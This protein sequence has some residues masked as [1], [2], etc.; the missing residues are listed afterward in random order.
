MGEPT[1][2]T[3]E[4]REQHFHRGLA[5]ERALAEL[6]AIKERFLAALARQ[7][8]A[9]RTQH[10]RAMAA[11]TTGEDPD[12]QAHQQDL[13]LD[14]PALST[15]PNASP[16]K[17]EQPDPEPP[18]GPGRPRRRPA[19]EA[20]GEKRAGKAASARTATVAE[21][22]AAPVEDDAVP[23]PAVPCCTCG[24]SL[25][26][27]TSPQGAV[28]A[29]RAKK[30]LAKPRCRAFQLG[31]VL[32]WTL[33]WQGGWRETNDKPVFFLSQRETDIAK[34]GPLLPQEGGLVYVDPVRLGRGTDVLAVARAKG[35]WSCVKGL[36]GVPL[37][38]LE[39]VA[40][41]LAE[42]SPAAPAAP[43]SAREKYLAETR[44]RFPHFTEDEV[45]RHVENFLRIDGHPLAAPPAFSG[46]D[47]TALLDAHLGAREEEREY[48]DELEVTGTDSAC[49]SC[50][51]REGPRARLSFS[52]HSRP[53]GV[54][55]WRA[56]KDSRCLGI[57]FNLWLCSRCC[58]PEALA[59][60]RQTREREATTVEGDDT[61]SECDGCTSEFPASQLQPVGPEDARGFYCEVCRAEIANTSPT[62]VPTAAPAATSSA[63]AASP[64]PSMP[65]N[66]PGPEE[67]VP[68]DSVNL[69]EVT[70]LRDVLCLLKGSQGSA[71]RAAR[72]RHIVSVLALSAREESWSHLA[73]HEPWIV[74]LHPTATRGEVWL[75]Y[76]RRALGT[77]GPWL[78][79]GE[80]LTRA[81]D[82]AAPRKG[83]TKGKS[84]EEALRLL[85][86]ALRAV[87]TALGPGG[88][89]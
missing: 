27:H 22:S 36:R 89:A 5:L 60:K 76:D 70:D 24:D 46:L 88:E 13:A 18:R 82:W 66:G 43:V 11:A 67:G 7:E 10:T 51:A 79:D 15:S 4:H 8:E 57:G 69:E 86:P 78:W 3:D 41:V 35:E 29:C 54:K 77:A 2:L 80:A 19:T 9:L 65:E 26:D 87:L 14:T 53:R 44:E 16:W 20:K 63:P 30:C 40:R 42:S 58:T 84:A 52:R 49:G 28:G 38:V 59:E 71:P 17:D 83:H 39:V 34:H 6:P 72:L 32:G 12:A 25:A 75:S 23:A 62:P 85:E 68:L 61:P 73:G 21:A 74:V 1:R 48:K 81:G 33:T 47:A 50:D 45:L 56:D 55:T 31:R 64:P 37:R